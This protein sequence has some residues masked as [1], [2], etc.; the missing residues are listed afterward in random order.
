MVQVQ[1]GLCNMC[2]FLD[3]DGEFEKIAVQTAFD[4]ILVAKG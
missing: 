3:G 1:T 4:F 2:V